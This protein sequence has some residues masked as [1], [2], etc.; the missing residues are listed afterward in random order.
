[1]HNI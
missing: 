1:V